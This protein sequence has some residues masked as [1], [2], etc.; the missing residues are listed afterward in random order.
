MQN[1]VFKVEFLKSKRYS[2]IF[3]NSTTGDILQEGDVFVW[4]NLA[5]TLSRIAENGA[6]EFYEGQTAQDLVFLFC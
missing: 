4:P 6:K 3:V 2:E 5:N 1:H